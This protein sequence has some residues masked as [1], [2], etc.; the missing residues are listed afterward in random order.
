MKRLNVLMPLLLLAIIY[1]TSCHKDTPPIDKRPNIPA[2][3][4]FP[5]TVGDKWI[6]NVY[7]SV[8]VKMEEVSVEITGTTILPKG[9]HATIWIYKYPDHIDTNFVFQ[10]GDTIKFVPALNL[11]P[12]DYYVSKKYIL[13]FSIGRVWVNTFI[14]DTIQVIRQTHLTISDNLKF[15]SVYF[16]IEAGQTF[17]YLIY[18]EEYFKPTIGT[19]QLSKYEYDFFPPENKVWYLKQY[20]LK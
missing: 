16:M 14:Y 6:Y 19:A 13:P 12:N 17:N 20:F 1:A 3:E 11:N 4:Y 2:S 15:D 10:S 7:D 5:N 9:E 18:A 8:S